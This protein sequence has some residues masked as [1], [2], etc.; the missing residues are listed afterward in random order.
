IKGA[1]FVDAGNIW[2]LPHY[3]YDKSHIDNEDAILTWNKLLK[4]SALSWG[5]GLR[6]D[7]SML[8]IRLDMGVKEYDPAAQAWRTP[9]QWF[10][11]DGFTLHFGVGYPF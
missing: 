2:E 9:G 10:K 7:L 1:F 8:V 6:L 5:V 4:S 11:R 3:T